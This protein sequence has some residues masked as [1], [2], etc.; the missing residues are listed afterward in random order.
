VRRFSSADKPEP[1]NQREL[2]IPTYW[3][4]PAR[5]LST[6]PGM[7]RFIW[8]LHYP[9]PDSLEHEYPISAIYHDTPRAPLGPAVLP[10]KYRVKLTVNGTTYAQPLTITMDPR[11]KTPEEGLRQQC[12]LEMKIS[13][14]MHRDYKTLQQVRSLRQ[15]VRNLMEKV[16]QGQLKEFVAALEG[17]VAELEGNEAGYGR[18]FLST[19]GGRS[20]TRLNVGLNTLLAA[21]DSADTAPTTQAVSTFSDLNNALEQQLA[22]WGEIKRKDVPELNLKLKVSGLPQLNLE[23]V[24]AAEDLPGN[25]NRAGDD[26]P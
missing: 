11:V 21:V 26:E 1:V 4:R 16:R 24:T 10:G 12:E 22:L 23:L 25:H 14:A 17:K 5:V 9:P 13:D 6:Q 2:N 7:H 19:P 8:D 15:Q 3:I 18:T 20:L